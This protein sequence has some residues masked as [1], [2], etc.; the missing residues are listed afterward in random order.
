MKKENV[1]VGMKAIYK[2]EAVIVR[3]VN[4]SEGSCTVKDAGGFV[5]EASITDLQ[6]L[7][8]EG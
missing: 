6:T 2:D 4:T 8:L 1:R 7:L 5:T 3:E